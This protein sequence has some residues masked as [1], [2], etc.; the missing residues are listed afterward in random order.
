M[1]REQTPITQQQTRPGW[2]RGAS[3]NTP[4]S[5]SRRVLL[6]IA[7]AAVLIAL[8]AVVY[9]ALRAGT[10]QSPSETEAAGS[11]L[12]HALHMHQG[13]AEHGPVVR[14]ETVPRGRVAPTGARPSPSTHLEKAKL[15]GTKAAATRPGARSR[16]RHRRAKTEEWRPPQF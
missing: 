16:P 2:V 1:S 15:S 5:G 6:S 13:G 10:A 8:A 4:H 7:L 14:I 11:R 3:P 9:A 12:A